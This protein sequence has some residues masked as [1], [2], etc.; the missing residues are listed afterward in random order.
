MFNNEQWHE[1]KTIHLICEDLIMYAKVA[2]V[3]VVKFTKVSA[4]STKA[5]LKGFDQT[6]GDRNV[7]Y[8][9]NRMKIV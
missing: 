5:L 2:C 8:R 3:R 9:Q 6:W 4:Y 7:L 1:S